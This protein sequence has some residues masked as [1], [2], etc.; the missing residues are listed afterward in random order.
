MAVDDPEPA[1]T[2]EQSPIVASFADFYDAHYVALVRLATA[3]VGRADVAE[4]LVQDSFMALHARWAR[5]SRY[6]APD[7]WMRR[8]VLNRSLS[9]QRRR[10]TELRLLARLA[11]QRPRSAEPPVTP[12]TEIWRLVAALP[13]RQ[14]QVIALMFVEDLSV[15]EVASVLE[16]D[17]NTVRTHYR[18]ARIALASQLG[19]EEDGA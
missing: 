2:C 13:K 17:E 8:V 1:G 19:L 15:R 9:T 18:R 6:D 7:M 5:V 10:T 14:A 12:D 3:L 4:E 11:R 16:C